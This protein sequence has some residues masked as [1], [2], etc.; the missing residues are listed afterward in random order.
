MDAIHRVIGDPCEDITQIGFR[1][2][3]SRSLVMQEATR[4]TFARP[5]LVHT[6][7]S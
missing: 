4:R 2:D 6:N 5:S 7:P 3:H 1:P